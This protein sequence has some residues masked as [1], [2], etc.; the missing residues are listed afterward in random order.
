MITNEE[1]ISRCLAKLKFDY[2]HW[3]VKYNWKGK[4]NYVVDSIIKGP[5]ARTVLGRGK[6][7]DDAIID[8][9]ASF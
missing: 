3:Q 5:R 2:P 6:T 1:E 4:Y 7:A 9:A 8:A